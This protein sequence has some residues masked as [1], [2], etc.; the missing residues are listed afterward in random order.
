MTTV[1]VI[2]DVFSRIDAA[3]TDGPKHP[4]ATLSPREI[5]TLAFMFAI[6]GV[7]HRPF[8]RGLER[9]WRACVPRLPERPRVCRLVNTHRPWTARVLAAPT[10]LGGIE[11]V[12]SM[13]TLVSHFTNMMP[14][15][16][17]YCQARL[18]FTMAA[19]NVL[20]QGDGLPADE[21]GFVPL[22]IAEFSL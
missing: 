7:G 11:T 18:A 4:P 5:V 21:D 3:M 1:D 8:S 19:F 17:A 10:I 2:T 6:K 15:V 22:S 20:V 14:R 9:D 12:L 16:W 13:L